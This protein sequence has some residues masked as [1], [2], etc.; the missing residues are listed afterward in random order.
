MEETIHDLRQWIQRHYAEEPNAPL[1]QEILDDYAQPITRVQSIETSSEWMRHDVRELLQ[2]LRTPWVEI[3][4]PAPRVFTA[5]DMEA[6]LRAAVRSTNRVW[7]REME[8][9]VSEMGDDG[10]AFHVDAGDVE[11]LVR[12]TEVF[13]S[14][15][16]LNS[17]EK[18]RKQMDK[19]IRAAISR[20]GRREQRLREKVEEGLAKARAERA[21]EQAELEL[22]RAAARAQGLTVGRGKR[23]RPRVEHGMLARRVA[24]E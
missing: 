24:R 12:M 7:R 19:V 6:R 14:L 16:T 22:R 3:I 18:V 21:R 4:N 20:R 23:A 9:W 8:Q 2:S 17:P 13:A 11:A 15:K 10:D 5:E 1:M